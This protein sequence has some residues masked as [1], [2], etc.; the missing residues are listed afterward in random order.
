ME[1]VEDRRGSVHYRF[2]PGSTAEVVDIG[3]LAE[4]RRQGV[5]RRLLYRAITHMEESGVRLVYAITRHDNHQAQQFWEGCGFVVA[6]ILRDFYEDD[7]VAVMYS[8]KLSS[9]ATVG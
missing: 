5:G 9:A 2:A 3:V 8:R 4:Y 6:G 7:A 1:V